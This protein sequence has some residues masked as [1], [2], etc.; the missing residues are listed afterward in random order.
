MN[1]TFLLLFRKNSDSTHSFF[2]LWITN[3]GLKMLFNTKWHL[4]NFIRHRYINQKEINSFLKVPHI[5]KWKTNICGIVRQSNKFTVLKSMLL[6]T[7]AF[8][9]L[10]WRKFNHTYYLSKYEATP[11]NENGD[12]QLGCFQHSLA[13][14]LLL[15]QSPVDLGFHKNTE[16][17]LAQI[18]LIL[19]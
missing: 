1:I 19:K 3:I 6:N 5:L 17:L 14:H 7:F 11:G 10:T 16:P 9:T 12:C 4:S 18:D 2:C 13:S 15:S 8:F